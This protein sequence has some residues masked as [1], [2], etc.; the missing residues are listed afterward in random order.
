VWQLALSGPAD[1]SEVSSD[2]VLDPFP[3]RGRVR[4]RVLSGHA[5]VSS[6]A[7]VDPG[8]VWAEHVADASG[9]QGLVHPVKRLGERRDLEGAQVGWQV[10][11][12]Q[13]PP[14]DV[15]GLR[16]AGPVLCFG[17]HA[18]VGVDAYCGGE[19]GCQQHGQRPGSA[20]DVQQPPGAV[21][22]EFVANGVSEAGRVGHAA[23][24][25][26]AGAPGEQRLVPLPFLGAHDRDGIGETIKGRS[27]IRS[28][29][30]RQERSGRAPTTCLPSTLTTGN[31]C[32]GAVRRHRQATPPGP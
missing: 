29:E 15:D 6:G 19:Q 32:A 23:D 9:D 11:G 2:Q 7:D 25:V 4:Q 13:V 28:Y 17:D 18:G 27:V 26:V 3:R 31:A 8:P 30:A 10:F 16:L 20:A 1:R 14:F 12:A 21:D 24:A 5:P 22:V